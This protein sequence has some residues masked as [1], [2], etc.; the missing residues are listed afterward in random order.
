VSAATLPWT[1]T[2]VTLLAGDDVIVTANGT[3]GV[4][5]SDPG[6]TP[7]ALGCAGDG[8]G[9]PV[10]VP[11]LQIWAPIAKIG[12]AAPFCIG[13]GIHISA[14]TSGKLY[15][16]FNDEPPFS[17]NWGGVTIQWQITRHP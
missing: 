10:Q 12:S 8:S 2:G 13:S 5:G 15:A 1:D 14:A 6:K 11:S 17:D 16:T 3:F 7:A 9:R 4:A